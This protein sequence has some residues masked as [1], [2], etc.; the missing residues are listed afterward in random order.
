MSSSTWTKAEL[1]SSIHRLCG[2]CWR[3]VEAQYINS[4]IKL[5]DTL[6]EQAIIEQEVEATKPP[7]PMECRHLDVLLYTPFRYRPYKFN[8]RFRRSGSLEGV[9]Y[10]SEN[11]ETAIAEQAF[12]R[13]LFFAD[14]PDTPFPE[15]PT[16]YTAF[17]ARFDTQKGIDL[18]TPPWADHKDLLSLIDYAECQRLAD[19]ARAEGV[20][21][22]RSTSVR[23]PQRRANIAILRCRAFAKP[24]TLARQ[25]WHIHVGPEGTR[26]YCESPR[27]SLMFERDAF[28]ADLRLQGF[29]WDRE[30]AF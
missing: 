28:T 24:N 14:S 10:A 4:T 25:T 27:L 19:A 9:F 5:T 23:D 26:A 13:L 8:S 17:E 7:I 30:I 16:E 2:N 11:P 3:V 15:N 1:L 21:V 6:E 22:I 29:S 18:T 12:R 20:G